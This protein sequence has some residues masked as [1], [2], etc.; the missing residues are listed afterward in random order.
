MQ[1]NDFRAKQFLSFDSL[2]GFKEMLKQVEIKKDNKIILEEDN[3]QYLDSILNKLNI[4]DKV[5]IKYYYLTEYIETISIIKKIDKINKKIYL[6]DS[7]I[8]IENIIDIKVI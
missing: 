8:D 5:L 7:I 6:K 2:K 3:K 4:N 1:N